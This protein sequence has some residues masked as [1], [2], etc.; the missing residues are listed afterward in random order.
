MI[1]GTPRE[2][3]SLSPVPSA[4]RPSR[5]ARRMLFSFMRL[6]WLENILG[7]HA[8]HDLADRLVVQDAPL[9][10]LRDRVDVAQTALERIFLE[11]RHRAAIVKQRIDDLP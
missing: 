4:A 11:H 5:T 2:E 8:E 6:S 9:P 7:R 1:H 10:L 3:N